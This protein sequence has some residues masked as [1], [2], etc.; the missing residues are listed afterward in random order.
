L[1]RPLYSYAEAD[2]LAGV[3]RGTSK[4]WAKGYWYR[5]EWGER[6]SQPPITA[7]SEPEHEAGV[8]FFD[9]V[10]IKAIDGLRRLRFSTRTIRKVVQ[11]CQDELQFPYPLATETFKTDRRRIY[12]EAGDGRLLEVLGGQRGA[13]AWDAILD[14][15]LETIDYQ[16]DFA[17]RWWP[18]G[19]DEL[20][21]VDPAYGFGAPVVVGSGV[22]T[23][24]VAE[25]AEV[26]D[27][28][29]VIAYDFN[30]TPEQ[31]ESALR[32]ESKLAA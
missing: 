5:G 3:S 19:K 26:G 23:E 16:N 12:I 29:E 1:I 6:V 15:F 18:L 32:F 2:R 7:G 27:R 8:S 20:V 13:Q 30:L 4:R 17:R 24:L 11:Y 31:V 28:P 25:R 14:P 10:G 22:R 9:L 21:V